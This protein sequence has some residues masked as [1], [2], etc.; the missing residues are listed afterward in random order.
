MKIIT[1]VGTSIFENYLDDEQNR[2][3]DCVDIYNDI[4][5]KAPAF[6]KW[7]DYKCDI[8][9]FLEKWQ[10]SDSYDASA[11]IASILKIVEETKVET[12]EVYLLATDTVLSVLACELI[13]EWFEE[14]YSSKITINFKKNNSFICKGLQVSNTREFRNEGLHHLLEN[15]NEIAQQD[16]FTNIVLNITGG[17]KAIIPYLTILGQIQ[18]I[19][20]AYIFENTDSLIWFPQ[21]PVNIDYS[22]FERYNKVFLNLIENG[23]EGSWLSYKRENDLPD[24]F[25]NFVDVIEENGIELFE[26]NTIG[27]YYYDRFQNYIIVNILKGNDI[28]SENAGNRRQIIDSLKELYNRLINEINQNS[29]I[30]EQD[31]LKHI[32]SLGDKHDLRHGT[33]PKKDIFIFKSTNDVH[34]RV[35]YTPILQ[36]GYLSL[37]IYDYKRGGGFDHKTYIQEFANKYKFKD[38]FEFVTV[39]ILKNE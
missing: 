18:Q 36:R 28:F 31:L 32:N 8:D 19:K 29:L 39:S 35:V 7:N 24:F 4:K 38:E 14:Y 17:Y 37:K 22:I 2:H 25:E 12:A 10:A 26:I 21:V 6:E 15:F 5:E 13:Q 34:I 20:I 11:E 9:E 27:K 16:Y 1:T 30:Q 23:G 33:N 3:Q